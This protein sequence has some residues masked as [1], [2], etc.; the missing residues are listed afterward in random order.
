[1]ASMACQTIIFW[2]SAGLG[3]FL[4]VV[5]MGFTI[6]YLANTNQALVVDGTGSLDAGSLA[7]WR[8]LDFGIFAL[9]SLLGIYTAVKS[10]A[11]DMPKAERQFLVL[12]PEGIVK[13]VDKTTGYDFANIQQMKAVNNRGTLTITM[14][15]KHGGKARLTLDGRFGN[16]K[17]IFR[18]LARAQSATTR[19][20]VQA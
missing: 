6:F 18:Q 4:I 15:L 9:F 12:T 8:T 17:Q 11:F 19:A 10:L 5:G 16:S 20:A 3:I 7:V 13:C 1:M 14:P 2:Q